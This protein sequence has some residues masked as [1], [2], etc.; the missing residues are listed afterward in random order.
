MPTTQNVTTTIA[1]VLTPEEQQRRQRLAQVLEHAGV[2]LRATQA[3]LARYAETLAG[4]QAQP[5]KAEYQRA[6][7][8]DATDALRRDLEA[9]AEADRRDAL[10]ELEQQIG[11][12][13]A[14]LRGLPT[15]APLQTT[16]DRLQAL[17]AETRA[18]RAEARTR[19]LERD[20]ADSDD[21]EAIAALFDEALEGEDADRMR[22]IGRAALARLRQLERAAMR[23]QPDAVEPPAVQAVRARIETAWTEWQR[24]HPTPFARLRAL[25]AERA[26]RLAAVDS[27]LRVARKLYGLE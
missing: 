15:T 24:A 1:P 26:A 19:D 20:I 8:E 11:R 13:K 10:R 3:R 4:I 14:E 7:T 12:T 25:E 23:A 27:T 18:L 16:D 22:R 2:P 5:F 21:P 6:L 17:L 9:A